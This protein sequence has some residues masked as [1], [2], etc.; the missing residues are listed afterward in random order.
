M[1]C[2]QNTR[3]NILQ[4]IR[5]V[6]MNKRLLGARI[7]LILAGGLALTILV[8][9]LAVVFDLRGASTHNEVKAAFYDISQTSLSNQL[10][11]EPE[12][13]TPEEYYGSFSFKT[14]GG[15]LS[16]LGVQVFPEDKVFAFPDPALGVGSR[17]RVYRAQNI[18]IRDASGDKLARSWAKTIS[19]LSDEQRLDLAEK[20]QVVPARETPIVYSEQVLTVDITRVAESEVVVRKDIEYT[21]KYIDD[22]TMER[23]DN[24]VEQAGVIGILEMK[25]LVRRENG[26]ETSRTLLEKNVTK[27]MEQKIVRR[28]T[29]I[30]QY[31]SG[32]ASWYG[33]VG[34]MTA[35]HL[36]L[37]KGTM[38]RVVNVSNGKS[39]VVRIA[40]RGPYV[41]GRIIDLSDDAY[42]LLAPLGSGVIN[43]RVEKE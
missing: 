14:S 21:T 11:P 15:M 30:V 12:N 1:I 7:R 20:D 16:N 28:G 3:Q 19:E 9:L 4:R 38:V 42:S 18:L 25:Y 36:T 26:V 17:L 41:A 37:P 22:A 40:D 24:K 27:E 31:G 33:G 43:V 23:G 32:K 2:H 13:R 8:Y 6:Y 34:A 5:C 10:G 39:V 35:A 29:K